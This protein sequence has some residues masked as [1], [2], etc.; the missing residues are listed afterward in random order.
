MGG[1]MVSS[2]AAL[3]SM[4]IGLG[5]AGW[6]GLAA[7]EGNPPRVVLVQTAGVGADRQT[8]IVSS[9]DPTSRV[10]AADG[11]PESVL[12]ARAARPAPATSGRPA[13]AAERPA[14]AERPA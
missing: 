10:V 9:S 11:H 4:A 3:A 8:T 12:G 2:R 13:A 14:S 5:L 1:D 7:A 6:A